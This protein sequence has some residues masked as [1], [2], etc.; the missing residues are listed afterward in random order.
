MDTPITQNDIEKTLEDLVNNAKINVELDR[1]PKL[2]RSIKVI[3]LETTDV[4]QASCPSCARSTDRE[5]FKMEK[6]HLKLGH[7]LTTLTREGLQSLEKVVMSGNYGDP[8]IGNS[9]LDIFRY[10]RELNPNVVLGLHSNGGLQST[11][12]WYELAKILNQPNDYVVF[13]IDGLEITNSEHRVGVSWEKLMQNAE[14]FIES[15]GHAIW[16]M[17][18]FKHNEHQV[19]E[20]M[21]FARKMGFKH[22]RAKISDRPMLKRMEI[23]ITFS[24]SL[25]SECE[26]KCKALNEESAFID[27]RGR[28]FPCQWLATPLTSNRINFD[29]IKDSWDSDEPNKTCKSVCGVESTNNE[30][31]FDEV[32]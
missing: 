29:E 2:D 32:L 6:H 24:R 1:G 21:E 31:V 17:L 7:L 28:I 26:I 22:F 4:C 16:E 13:S 8:A 10:I 30:W 11:F 23:P 3:H 25:S 15:G 20:C 18:I 27:A 12:W 5:Y 14:S 19:K 9:T